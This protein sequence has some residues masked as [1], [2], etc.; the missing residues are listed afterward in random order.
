MRR[1]T[2]LAGALALSACAS[3][4]QSDLATAEAPCHKQKFAEKTALAQCLTEAERPVWAKDEPQTLDLYDRF[5]A[6]RTALAERRD[7]GTLS[8][9]EYEQRLDALAQDLRGRIAARRA[10]AE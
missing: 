2:I 10:A 5:A 9:E 1:F 3:A 4:L 6:G 7:A 8:E